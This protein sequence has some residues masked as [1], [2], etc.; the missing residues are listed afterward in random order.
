MD[1]KTLLELLRKKESSTLEF[2]QELYLLNDKNPETKK[3]QK[4]ELIKDVLALANGNS[5]TAGDKAYLI[6]GADND[7]NSNGERN[8][9]DVGE[10][11]ITS[12]QILDIVNNACEPALEDIICEQHRVHDKRILLIIVPPT[13]HL[14]ET[15]F[16]LETPSTTYSEHTAFV[17]HNEGVAIAS[18][19]ERDSII[20]LKRFRFSESSN[21]PADIFGAIIGGSMGGLMA[22]TV[23]SN[24]EKITHYD[25]VT[26]KNKSLGFVGL[27]TGGIVGGSIGS[28]YKNF[29]QIRSGWNRV[30]PAMRLPLISITIS[31]VYIGT[32]LLNWLLKSL[33]AWAKKQSRVN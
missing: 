24:Y 18:Q 26:K 9:Y 20:Q 13:P 21:P 28:S 22:Y 23:S 12:K 16:R 7:F 6:I 30:P 3:R 17:R 25:S 14:H 8:L 19:R 29:Y 1:T 15:I 11:S 5:I 32:K 33:T 10:H 31:F 2:K 27:I 4:N